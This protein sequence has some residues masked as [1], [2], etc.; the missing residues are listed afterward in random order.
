M[1]DVDEME[2]ELNENL[3][4]NTEQPETP[5]EEIADK[6]PEKTEAKPEGDKE[7]AKEEVK[8]EKEPDSDESSRRARQRVNNRLRAEAAE[9][10]LHK[11]QLE[12]AKIQGAKEATAARTT[13]NPDVEPDEALDPI[14]HL[15]WKN[16]QLEAKFQE[17]EEARKKLEQERVYSQAEKLWADTDAELASSNQTYA[18]AKKHLVDTIGA[19]LKKEYPD[20]SPSQIKA[21]LRAAEYEL[22]SSLAKVN[23]SA[24]FIANGFIAEAMAHGFNPAQAV[25]PKTTPTDTRPKTDPREVAA[26]K[27]VAGSVATVPQGGGA[28]KLTAGDVAK[29]S[30]MKDIFALADLSDADWRN[31]AKEVSKQ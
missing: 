28:G 24:G 26:H 16:R 2:K 8:E 13:T 10:E 4:A 11:A 22:V 27:K 15:Q 21:V 3:K 1:F 23:D 7:E 19:N 31:M 25:A 17:G 18:A 12:L 9:R 30:T 5:V 29:M 20:A 6:P 14:A